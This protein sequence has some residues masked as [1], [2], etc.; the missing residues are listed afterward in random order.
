[1]G[2]VD[3]LDGE[4]RGLKE[5]Q[6]SKGNATGLKPLSH[7]PLIRIKSGSNP[8]R[9]RI[10]CVHT[11]V[12]IRIKMWIETYSGGGFDPHSMRIKDGGERTDLAR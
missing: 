2:G 10:S 9:I 1:M 8:D 5:L 3:S 4:E 7:G 12:L 6:M 11:S